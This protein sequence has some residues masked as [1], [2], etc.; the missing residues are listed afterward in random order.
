[1]FLIRIREKFRLIFIQ[2]FRIF[3]TS[4]ILSNR[5]FHLDYELQNQLAKK[6]T[7]HNVLVYLKHIAKNELLLYHFL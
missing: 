1:M 5:F 6:H 4:V 2:N 7:I 3:K